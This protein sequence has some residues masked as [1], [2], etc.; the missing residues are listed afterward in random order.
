MGGS[1][2]VADAASLWVFIAAFHRYVS[3]IDLLVAYGLANVLAVIPITPGGLGVVEGVLIPTLHGFHV[4][5]K[6]ALLG[7]LGYRLVNFWLPIPVGGAT[8]VSLRFTSE[9]WRERI[10]SVH[11][12]IIEHKAP[13][14]DASASDGQGGDGSTPSGTTGTSASAPGTSTSSTSTPASAAEL[15]ASQTGTSHSVAGPPASGAGPSASGA[16]TAPSAVSRPVP[17]GDTDHDNVIGPTDR[18]KAVGPLRK[19]MWSLGFRRST[20]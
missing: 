16:G 5:S 2:L 3:P 15:P 11:D 9:G 14:D 8:Y 13:V 20:A 10:H 6:V 19:M 1:E 18:D 7:V 12:E 17:A 4:P